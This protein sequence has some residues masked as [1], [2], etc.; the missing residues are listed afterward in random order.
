VE[1]LQ[2]ELEAYRKLPGNTPA[3]LKLLGDPSS[4]RVDKEAAIRALLQQCDLPSHLPE[5]LEAFQ[6]EMDEGLHGRFKRAMADLA[7]K[8]GSTELLEGVLDDV[9]ESGA[10]GTAGPMLAEFYGPQGIDR[11]RERLEDESPAV[12][13]AAAQAFGF[14]PKSDS[15]V[16]A[17]RSAQASA[18]PAV[19]G[20]SAFGLAGHDEPFVYD[21]LVDDWREMALASD[22]EE[23]RQMQRT[24]PEKVFGKLSAKQVAQVLLMMGDLAQRHPDEGVRKMM[25]DSIR[26]FSKGSEGK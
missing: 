1:Q 9:R 12:R 19:R 18:D 6:A 26:G 25:G 14:L 2:G 13:R 17:L 15:V 7:V 21:G 10:P 8:F 16:E 5:V 3:L 23:L 4:P 24:P 11:I 20:L 22:Q